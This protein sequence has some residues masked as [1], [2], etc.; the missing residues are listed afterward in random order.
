LS[1]PPAATPSGRRQAPSPP[2]DCR[3]TARCLR[4]AF[5]PL[6]LRAGESFANLR[7]ENS[8]ID[9]FFERRENDPDGGEGGERVVQVRS[10]PV[11]KLTSGRTRAATWFDVEHPPQAV[12]WLLDAQLHDERHQGRAD[13]YDRFAELEAADQLFPTDVDYKWLELDRRRLDTES[14]AADVRRDARRLVEE[15]RRSGRANGTLAGVPSR[16]AW[17]AGQGD[18]PSLYVAVSTQPVVGQRSG[19]EFPLTN[20]RFLLLAEAVRQA[21]E[22]LLGPQVLVGEQLA[23]PAVLGRRDGERIVLVVFERG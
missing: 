14:F 4:E 15:A 6:H 3:L 2:H 23:A 18:L 16:L 22:S 17:E 12:V 8:V 9:R 7:S 11:F 1:E 19:Y 5:H 21:G 13:A 10:R 20:A